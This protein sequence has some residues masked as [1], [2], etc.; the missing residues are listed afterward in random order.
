MVATSLEA[1]LR[2]D[3]RA[4]RVESTRQAFEAF[5]P[6]LVEG[7]AQAEDP[8]AAIVAFDRFLAALQRGGRLIGLLG[9]N[10]DLVG[11]LALI[12]GAAPRL[13]DM[14]AR[15]PQIIDGLVDPRFFGPIPSRRELSG[16]LAA[17]LADAGS[18]EEFLDRL[19]LFGQ[20]SLFLIGARILSGTVSAQ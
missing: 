7:L 6:A 5:I 20:E 13:G 18:Y 8:D 3:Y 16:R 17:Q 19:R 4:L 9:Q 11:L 12:L 2:G 10:P 14:L 15:Q 1:W